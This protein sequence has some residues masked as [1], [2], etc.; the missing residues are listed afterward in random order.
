MDIHYDNPSHAADF[1]ALNEAWIRE[2]FALVAP[3]RALV[4]EGDGRYQLARMA[5]DAAYRGRGLGSTL[6]LYRKHGFREVRE[7]AK[8]FHARYARCDIVMELIL[9]PGAGNR[10]TT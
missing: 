2:H 4:K 5:V 1:V 7:G 10:G 9:V 6:H 8:E 3:D